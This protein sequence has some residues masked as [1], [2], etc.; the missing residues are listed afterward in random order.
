MSHKNSFDEQYWIENYSEPE[1][2]DGLANATE[3]L[4]YL[5]CLFELENIE[6]KRIADFGFGLGKLLE[7]AC[8][9]FVPTQVFAL[10]PS[11]HAF[12]KV[13]S[14]EWT[15]TWQDELSWSQQDLKTWSLAHK[16]KKFKKPQYDLGICF[17]VMQY[18]ED[19]DLRLV[20]KVLAK[21]CRYLYAS[22]PTKTELKRQRSE[23][24][25]DDRYA[26]RRS[27]KKYLEILGEDWT[28]VGL[29]LLESK[30]HES[31]ES[32]PFSDHLFRF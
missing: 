10:E 9:I 32:S 7:E 22:M 16:D 12:D 5:Y 1:E 29:R 28:I 4:Q 23:F 3:H 30:H 14:Q 21:S 13:R 24:E 6:V 18:I 17:S 19:D 11:K 27:R 8:R 20:S 26:I 25:F 31:Y 15:K 2:M